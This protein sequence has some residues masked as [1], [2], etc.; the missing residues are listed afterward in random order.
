MN[1]TPLARTSTLKAARV[2]KCAV[3]GCAN[4]FQPRNISHK[5]CGPACAEVHAAAE[6]KRLDAKQTRE[7]KAKLKTRSD[8]LKEAQAAFNACMRMRDKEQQCISCGTSLRYEAIGGGFDCGHYR[9]VGS[10][11]HLRFN[12][13]N[14]HGQCKKCNRYGSGMAVDYRIGLIARI[15]LA[16]VEAL[17]ADQEPRK[18]SVDELIEIKQHY[19]QKLKQLKEAT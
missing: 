9:S 1:R 6:R 13:D 11:P 17:E 12:E 16:R 14:A 5:V 18:W 15:G 2:R 19:R 7:R 10:A 3:K 8:Y 4:R